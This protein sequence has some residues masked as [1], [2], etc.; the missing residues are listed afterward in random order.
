[1]GV[2]LAQFLSG[3]ASASALFLAASGLSIIFG[4]T[5]VVNFAHGSF[6]MLGAYFGYSLVRNLGGGALG[7]WVALLIASIAVGLVGLLVEVIILRRLYKAPELFQ[8]IATFGVILVIQDVVFWYWGAENLLGPRAPGLSGIVRIFDVPM[9]VYDLALIAIGP[10]V[11]LGLWL[12]FNRTRWGVLVRAATEDREMVGALGVN[13]SLLFTGVFVLGSALA[14]LGG[15]IQ[16]P[17]GDANLLM[18]FGILAEVF[19]VTVVGGMGSIFGAFLAAVLI[20]E[21]NTFGILVWP[22]GTLVLMFILMAVIL[23]VRPTGLLGRPETIGQKTETG[24]VEVV[25]PAGP[26]YKIFVAVVIALLALLPLLV[27]DFILVLVTDILV[28]ALFA[29]SLHFLMSTGGLVSFGHAAFYGGGAYA[30]ALLVTYAATPF[31]LALLLAPFGAGLLALVIGWFCVRLSGV[32]FAMLTLAFAQVAWSVVFQ[33]SD[34]TNGDDGLLGIWPA[35]WASGTATYYYVAFVVAAAGIFLIRRVV[36]APFGYGLRATRD[37]SLRAAA[38]G[39]DIKRQQLAAFVFAGVMAGLA[40]GLFAFSKGSVFPDE[41]SIPRSFDALLMVLLGGIESLSGP[42]VG[43]AAFTWLHDELITFEYWRL[44]L[45]V[46]IVALVLLF[47]QGLG[48]AARHH[49]GRYLKLEASP[50]DL[51]S[52]TPKREQRA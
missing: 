2:Y 29:T 37:S 10:L 35:A 15:A 6:Y 28:L 18:D 19:V 40:G 24:P 21:L 44:L 47:P 11:L 14:G 52:A 34:V 3:L 32:Y 20:S 25:L 48:G 38:I 51:R 41:M 43:A 5:R 7:F 42:V 13:Q 16:L 17:K 33:W 49:V 9:P 39:I 26:H 31:E 27:D 22:N 36:F 30:A 8:L 4:V 12:L 50:G 46:V 23:I 1:M 45:G